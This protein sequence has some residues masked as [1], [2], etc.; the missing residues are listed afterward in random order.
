MTRDRPCL[1]EQRGHECRRVTRAEGVRRG[2]R[3]GHLGRPAA[4]VGGVRRPGQSRRVSLDHEQA[5]AALGQRRGDHQHVGS[6]AVDHRL[7]DPVEHPA[8]ALGPR[9]HCRGGRGVPRA[10]LGVRPGQHRLAGHQRLEQGGLL[11][12]GACRRDRPSGQDH[13][14]QERLRGQHP[15]E[16]LG[17]DPALHGPGAHAAVLLGERQPEDAHLGQPAPELL[18]EAGLGGRDRAAPLEV[19]VGLAHQAAHR[20]AERLLL[21]VVLEV[22][23]VRSF[24]SPRMVREMITRWISLDPP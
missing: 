11:L 7:L 13:R 3:E 19:G 15:A 2:R 1:V 24:Q 21:V 8:V 6:A 12:R 16:L 14:G 22:H 20:V 18:V 4:V 9:G 10:G 17:H 5:G 23:V